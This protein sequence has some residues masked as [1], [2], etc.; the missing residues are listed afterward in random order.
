MDPRN[1]FACDFRQESAVWEVSAGFITVVRIHYPMG[2]H[3]A[4]TMVHSCMR[5]HL[6][7]QIWVHQQI[8]CGWIHQHWILQKPHQPRHQVTWTRSPTMQ[9]QRIHPTICSLQSKTT[10]FHQAFCLQQFHQ[11]RS[12]HLTILRRSLFPKQLIPM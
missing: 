1:S 7:D 6:T 9:L 5:R 10:R 8:A 12:G 11:C 2:K 3:A 4:K